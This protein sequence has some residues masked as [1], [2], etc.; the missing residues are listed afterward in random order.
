MAK[1]A[2]ISPMRRLC[3]Q[4]FPVAQGTKRGISIITIAGS[5]KKKLSVFPWMDMMTGEAAGR[6]AA[7][8][9][10]ANIEVQGIDVNL[11]QTYL[12]M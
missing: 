10:E 3:Q 12:G 1:I 9:V 4:F 11:L 7:M 6:A 8:A 2:N 5:T